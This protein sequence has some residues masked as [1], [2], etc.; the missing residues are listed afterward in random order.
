MVALKLYDHIDKLPFNLFLDCY[1]DGKIKVLIIEGEATEEDL[2]A[3]WGR[4]LL[5]ICGCQ[6]R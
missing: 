5:P 4:D 3:A 1:C 6:W 2:Q